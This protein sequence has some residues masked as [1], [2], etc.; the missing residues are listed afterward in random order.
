[1]VLLLLLT[2]SCIEDLEIDNTTSGQGIVIEG[3]ITNEAPPYTILVSKTIPYNDS[4]KVHPVSDAKVYLVT[5]DTEEELNLSDSGTYQSELIQGMVNTTY[6]MRVIYK[7]VVYEAT[8]VMPEV[9]PIDSVHVTEAEGD[10]SEIKI[11]N[12]SL[13]LGKKTNKEKYYYVEI[14]VNGLII[15]TFTTLQTYLVFSDYYMEDDRNY[16]IPYDFVNGSNI[17][18]RLYS[19]TSEIFEYYSALNSRFY[20][21]YDFIHL[22]PENPPTNISNGALGYFQASAVV[23][24]NIT[25]P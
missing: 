21:Y 1:M 23:E 24:R 6:T 10:D 17:H 18:I 16:T 8:S 5:D 12:L 2:Y 22:F 25:L 20:N 15:N 3:L 19:I 13:Y 4:L 7:D 9:S 14:S 11:C